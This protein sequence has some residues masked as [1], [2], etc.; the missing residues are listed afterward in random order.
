MNLVDSS[1]WLE[2]FGD[3]GNADFFAPAIEDTENLIVSA[4]NIYEVF[5]KLLLEKDENVALHAVA[6]M[7]IALVQP[8]N[9]GIALAG[10]RIS[11]ESGLP[12]ADGLILATA[13]FHNAVL[14]TQDS[15]FVNIQG[16]KFIK[17]RK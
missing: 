3:G 17:A 5:K 6:A 7:R 1:G 10:A 9:E 12:M 14:W 2:Y 11:H 13:R 4:I 16:V 15:D 8:V